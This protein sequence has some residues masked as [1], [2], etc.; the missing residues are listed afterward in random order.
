[1][2]VLLSRRRG[3]VTAGYCFG[4]FGQGWVRCAKEYQENA[5]LFQEM[6]FRRFYRSVLPFTSLTTLHLL[7]ITATFPTPDSPRA[8]EL[9]FGITIP[10][11]SSFGTRH[12]LRCHVRVKTV[13]SV[14]RPRSARLPGT[15]S[16]CTTNKTLLDYGTYTRDRD[17]YIWT[18]SSQCWGQMEQWFVS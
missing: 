11:A 3:W 1:V 2:L 16:A 14:D 15:L 17:S 13:R 10:A 9:I 8:S 7:L 5:P 18:D 6:P 4:S 12:V